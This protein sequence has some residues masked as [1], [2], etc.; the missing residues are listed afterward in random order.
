MSRTAV[1]PKIDS[2]AV[3][4]ALHPALVRPR[5]LLIA[6]AALYFS[7]AI[8]AAWNIIAH[9]QASTKAIE[10]ILV[11]YNMKNEGSLAVDRY[12][13]EHPFLGFFMSSPV[14]HELDLPSHDQAAEELTSGVR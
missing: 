10:N 1:L 2:E 9:T 12:A 7:A 6:L 8:P 11:T 5:Y 4:E 3:A 13:Q 14:K